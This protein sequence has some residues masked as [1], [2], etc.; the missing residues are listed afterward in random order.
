[1]VDSK[2]NPDNFKTLEISIAE[3]IE[4]PEMLEVIL[5]LILTLER[6][7]KMQLRSYRS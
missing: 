7:V 1:M 2:N 4:D 5:L 3:I 6:F